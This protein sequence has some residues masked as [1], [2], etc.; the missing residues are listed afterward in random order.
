MAAPIAPI[1]S[2][3]LRYGAVALATYAA[4]RAIPKMRRDQ[5]VEDCLD[6]V[7]E[8]IELRQDDGQFN[9][10]ARFKRTI[11]MHNSGPGIEVDFTSL[12]RITFRRVD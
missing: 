8:G 3:A 7:E 12:A 2:L 6:Q 10:S 11:R 4:T 9:G 1:A 5:R